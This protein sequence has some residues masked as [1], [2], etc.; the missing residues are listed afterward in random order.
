MIVPMPEWT[1]DV[2]ELVA[3]H[4][5]W[6]VPICFVLGLGESIAVVSLFVPSTVLFL[7]IGGALS[8]AGGSFIPIW[9]AGAVG[10][11]VGDVASFAL[12][13]AYKDQILQMWPLTAY[14]T[15]VPKAKVAID[16]WG[17][18]SIIGSK[19]V[20]GLRPFIPLI[21]GMLH[22]P[23]S[24]FLPASAVSCLIWSGVFLAPGYGLVKLLG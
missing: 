3:A 17:A 1:K 16:K 13:R 9:L 6:A 14:P 24:R 20:G 4:Q 19:F 22:I 23:F 12:G 2:V 10:A 11:F 8:A 7:G 21:A 5:V 18:T 15:M